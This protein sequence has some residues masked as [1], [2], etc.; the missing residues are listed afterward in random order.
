MNEQKPKMIVWWTLWIAFLFSICMIYNVLGK[1]AANTFHPDPF[2]WVLAAIPVFFSMAVRWLV[3][4]RIYQA[5]MAMVAFVIGIAFAE[6]TCFMG[7]FIL[8][9]HRSDLFAVS[10]FGIIQFM[11]YYAGRF[12]RQD[13]I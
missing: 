6:S 7:L 9:A 12:Y 11:P 5:Q 3:L 10:V 13:G 1:Q 4:P 8:P 2:P